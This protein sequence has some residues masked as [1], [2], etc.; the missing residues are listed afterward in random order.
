MTILYT[1]LA[2]LYHEMYQNLFDYQ[3]DFECYHQRLQQYGCRSISEIGCGSGNLAAYFVANGYAYQGLDASP[4]MLEIAREI[5]PAATYILGDMRSLEMADE[6]DAILITGR[7]FSYLNTN[8]DVLNTLKGI[9][10]ALHPEGLLCFDNFNADKIIH[11]E[12]KVFEQTSSFK[13]KTFQRI[14]SK[15]L[16]LDHGWTENWTAKYLVSEEGKPTQEFDDISILRSFTKDELTI[17]LRLA[18]FGMEEWIDQ[19]SIF[20]TVAKKINDL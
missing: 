1:K 12:P 8:W 7:S 2:Y 19:E 16:N 9:N 4:D 14:S 17:F 5:E 15:T 6:F 11:P 20:L 13:G 3:K 10:R 18:G